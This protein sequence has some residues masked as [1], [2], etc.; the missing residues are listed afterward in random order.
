LFVTELNAN[1]DGL[2]Y[3][4][5]LG[6]SGNDTAA[7]IALD[8]NGG[9][10]VT[11]WTVSTVYPTTPGVYETANP[12]TSLNGHATAVISKI[13]LSSPTSCHAQISPSGIKLPGRGGVAS[14]NLTLAPGCPWE[15]LHEL[16]VTVNGPVTGMGSSAAIPFNLTVAPND[17]TDDRT[18]TVF[19]GD[20]SFRIDQ[21]K[22]TCDDPVFT[23]DSFSVGASGGIR[24][25]SVAVPFWCGW[26]AASNVPWVS[27][28]SNPSGYG[29]G[30][31]AVYV[32]PNSFGTRIGAVTIGRRSVSFTQSG[33]ACTAT[34]TT[35]RTSFTAT[36]GSGN[37]HITTGAECTWA[38]YGTVPWLQTGSTFGTG[39][40]SAIVPFT[41]AA[42]PS[43]SGRSGVILI[44][45]QSITVSQSAGPAGNPTSYVI[46]IF[47]GGGSDSSVLGDGGP[48]DAAYLYQPT[49]LATTSSAVY[50]AANGL[51]RAVTADGNINTVAGGGSA[52]GDGIPPTAARISPNF[53]AMDTARG[54]LY[55]DTELVVRRILGPGDNVVTSVAGTGVSGFSGDNGP[56][57]SAQVGRVRALAVDPAGALYIADDFYKRIRKVSG[58]IITTFANGNG[59]LLGDGGVATSAQFMPLGLAVDPSGNV[60]IADSQNARIR[61]IDGRGIITTIAGS[62]V[63]SAQD[64]APAISAH[65]LGMGP[66]AADAAGVIYFAADNRIR[67]ISTDGLIYTLTPNDSYTVRS[68]ATDTSG[69][70][71]FTETGANVVHKL[72]PQPSF[73]NFTVSTTPAPVAGGSFSVSVSTAAGCTWNATA[74]ATNSWLTFAGGDG[75]GSGTMSGTIARN[76]GKKTRR[77]TIFIAGQAVTIVQPGLSGSD[78]DGNG[79]PDLVWQNYATRQVTVHYYGGSG[80]ASDQGWNWLNS[81][82]NAGWHVVAIADFNGDGTPDLVWQNDTTRQVTVHYYGAAGGAS[83]QGWNWLNGGI[84]AGWRVVAAAD[85]NGDGVPDLVWQNDIT[86]QVT[87]NYYGGSGGAVYQGWKWLNSGNNAGW[88][89]ATVADFNGDGAP[90]LVWQ[91]DTTRQV[92][93]HYYGGAGGDEDQGWNWLNTGVNAGW[94]VVAATDFNGDGVPDLIWQYEPT[95][96]VTVNYYGGSGGAVYQGWAWLYDSAPGWSVVNAVAL[97]N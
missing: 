10:Y 25:M 59:P 44:G 48:A 84:N 20:A 18:S 29:S 1:G 72:T 80:G 27:F 81:G 33:G 45:D 7:G 4:T 6:G 42:N 34:V 31:L 90:D 83:D 8:G 96:Q 5:L 13:D 85:F 40:G 61:K 12:K 50:I 56:A 32:T 2:V 95:G 78:F 43:W 51:I 79:T 24:T 28:T 89:V 73:C 66:V 15:A 54:Y 52:M 14:F 3:S 53:L 60:L 65:F 55:F 92:T 23:P 63:L 91:N 88:R 87:V 97:S 69:N 57:I 26:S 9:V 37:L 93:V 71:Y 58:G 22:W 47:A 11:G 70:V 68:I 62:G 67:K 30:S 77:A 75:S 36:G 17:T 46:S 16:A 21:S 38:A 19:I 64:G 39:Q 74:E 82:N 49:G 76:S 41:V 94:R 86:R 35:S